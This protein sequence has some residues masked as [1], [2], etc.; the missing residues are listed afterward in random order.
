[1]DDLIESGELDTEVLFDKVIQGR[2]VAMEIVVEAESR[3]PAE[4]EG[5]AV[6]EGQGPEANELLGRVL[7]AHTPHETLERIG[8]LQDRQTENQCDQ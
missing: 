3:L 5:R 7:Q 8:L 2:R 1:V 6:L 4:L